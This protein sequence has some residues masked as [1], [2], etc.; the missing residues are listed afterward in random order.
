MIYKTLLIVILS[1]GLGFVSN[2]LN[3]NGIQ[4]FTKQENA[5]LTQKSVP[6][7]PVAVQKQQVVQLLKQ[8]N[9]LIIDARLPDAYHQS[10]IP[11]A[12]NISF[13]QLGMHFDK[14][15]S[16]PHD[17]WLITYCDDSA[18]DLSELLA[19]EL[20]NLG[21]QFVGYYKG[22]LEEW[23]QTEQVMHE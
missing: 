17:Q 16:L 15:E 22:G 6:D 11:G 19:H 20:F 2:H 8:E 4:V 1:A 12:V 3:P 9:A 13:E 7:Q 5:E 10:H 23:K 21:Y 18:C 14:I